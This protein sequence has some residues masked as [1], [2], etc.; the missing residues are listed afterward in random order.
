M[1]EEVDM[2]REEVKDN[3]VKIIGEVLPGEDVSDIADDN[4]P[5]VNRVEMDSM[6][7]LDIVLSLTKEYKIDIPDSDFS[8][9]RTMKDTL[10][11]LMPKIS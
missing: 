8:H 4:V 11:Y 1:T 3:L 5:F 7:F 10:D 2:T 6:D 9:L